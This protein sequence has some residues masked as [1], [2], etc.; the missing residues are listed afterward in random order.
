VPPNPAIHEGVEGETVLEKACRD[1]FL[2]GTSRS[3]IY[4]LAADNGRIQE[5]LLP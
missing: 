2:E 3:S 5:V 1:Y 4:P